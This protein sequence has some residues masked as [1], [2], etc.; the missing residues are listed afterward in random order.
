MTVELRQLHLN[1]MVEDCKKEMREHPI[2]V[3][4]RNTWIYTKEYIN[5]IPRRIKSFIQRG[6][7][8]W[9]DCDTWSFD[10]Y[11]SKII[12]GGVRY[13][14]DNKSGYPILNG[15]D[16]DESINRYNTHADE[17]A[18]MWLGI[19]Y[20]I[21]KTFKTAEGISNG[22]IWYI[23]SKE[24]TEKEYNTL[25]KRLKKEEVLTKQESIEYE[26]G[27]DLFKKYFHNLWD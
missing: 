3:K 15:K 4:L 16:I 24:W 10:I 20:K 6:I 13:L 27:F 18:T 23:P 17:N 7:R 22:D 21:I 11:L 8:G 19:L 25:S 14:R 5:S 12:Y 2:R 26:E 9:S 1:K